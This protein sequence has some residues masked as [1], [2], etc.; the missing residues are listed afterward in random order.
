VLD[1]WEEEMIGRPFLRS[2]VRRLAFLSLLLAVVF[3]GGRV[4]RS[5]ALTVPPPK[6]PSAFADTTS[7]ELATDGEDRLWLLSTGYR[8]RRFRLSIHRYGSDSWKRLKP[9]PQAPSGDGPV[10]VVWKPKTI[11][12]APCLGFTEARRLTPIITCKGLDRWYPQ[13]VDK[14][15]SPKA[16]LI[17]LAQIG[18]QLFALFQVRSSQ[19]DVGVRVIKTSVGGGH[20]EAAGR[21]L[22]TGPALARLGGAGTPRAPRV[23]LAVETQGRNPIRYVTELK[24]NRWVPP[25]KIL[26][27]PGLGPLLSGPVRIG[28]TTLLPVVDAERSP[29]PF[30]VYSSTKATAWRTGGALSTGHGNAQGRID[31][32]A[33]AVWA[34][35][36]EHREMQA[37]GFTA[38]NWVAK[39]GPNG[40]PIEKR[41]LWSGR[42]VGPG[43]TQVIAFRGQVLALYMR[44]GSSGRL[45]PRIMAIG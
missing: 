4:D 36:Q 27:G 35:W 8:K 10:N 23:E 32:A 29:W 30:S 17:E 11:G 40:E 18:G 28:E 13:A 19:G 34:S 33:G 12:P 45:V 3:A 2:R 16:K 9:P 26:K 20:W 37:G 1:Q 21:M 31:F 41:R 15:L 7:A 25:S 39:M 14:L 44:G 42:T 6:L 24:D 38:I 43:S 5:H 22:E